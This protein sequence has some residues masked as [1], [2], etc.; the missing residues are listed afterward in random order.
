M[1]VID[2]LVQDGWLPG[3]VWGYLEWGWAEKGASREEAG[4]LQ[5]QR[6]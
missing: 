4:F 6:M 2:E 1:K 5:R 3:L